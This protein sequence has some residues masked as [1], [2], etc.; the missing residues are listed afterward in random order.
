MKLIFEEF[1]GNHKTLLLELIIQYAKNLKV[2]T[3]FGYF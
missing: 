3:F 1:E 2:D